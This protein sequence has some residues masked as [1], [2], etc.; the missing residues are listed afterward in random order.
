[1][2]QFES[3]SLD[4][5]NECLWRSGVQITLPPKP[6]SILRYLVENP[7]RLITHDELLDALWPETY[8]QPQVLRTYMLDLRKVLGDDA[9]QPRFIQT[10]PKRG[11][12]FVA[13]VME[14]AG[15]EA[16][17]APRAATQGAQAA[18]IVDRELEF[19]RLQAQLQLVAGGQRQV[20]F[21]SGGAGIGKTA[22]VDSFCQE[23]AGTSPEASV[24]HGQCVEGLGKKEDYYP[25]ME[26]LCQLCASPAGERACRILTRIAPAWLPAAGWEPAKPARS[27]AQ[28][29]TLRMPGDLCSALEE[30]A[31][32]AALILVI[33]DIHWADAATLELLSAL[34]RRRTPTK[35]MV[36]A[37]YRPEG[38]SAEHP[39]R[40]LTQDLL[41]HRL[42]TELALMPLAKTAI[43][44]LLFRQLGQETLPNG[45]D[46]F[47]YQHS[48]GNPLFA[49][50][51]LEHLIAERILVREGTKD[52]GRWEQRAPFPEIASGVPN[53]LAQLIE[54]EFRRLS[55]EEQRI[56]EAASLMCIAF[57]AWAVA[58]AL[59]QDPAEMEE[60]CDRLASRWCFVQRAGHD[61][62]PDGTRSDFYAFAHGLYREVLY[63]KQPASRRAK[64]HIRIAERLGELF[65]GRE[66]NVAREMAMH[67]EAAGDWHRAASAL[68][69]AAKLAQQ[70]HAYSEAAQLLEHSLGIAE[71][72]SEIDRGT[73]GREIQCELEM[74][75]KG[76]DVTQRQ[77]KG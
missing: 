70:R 28:T 18:G 57:P 75:L 40:T 43:R 20:V 15:L 37:T 61:D 52:A 46:S 5:S 35:L 12:R 8:V 76:I 30:L 45:L 54:V 41:T 65:A 1:M 56:L 47:I 11:Y 36:V 63:Q 2:K 38:E 64:G 39:F 4:T 53:E 62:L 34:A 71:N 17:A 14:R 60:A 31:Q 29:M 13:P 33:E 24:A 74:A 7:G 59:K 23:A 68:R 6:F 44:Q 67:F 48:E 9:G 42:S 49:L 21:V 25:I 22:L 32:E 66:A 26:A 16:G 51:L 69:S 27:G 55:P 19:R 3:F 72:L 10:L 77:Q 50:T 73:V 58:A